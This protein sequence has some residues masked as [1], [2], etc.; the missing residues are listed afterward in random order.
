MGDGERYER[1]TENTRFN[2]E[3]VEMTVRGQTKIKPHSDEASG[4]G[5]DENFPVG[6]L[7]R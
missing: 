4:L 2:F 1:P 7:I 5:D 3:M 6:L